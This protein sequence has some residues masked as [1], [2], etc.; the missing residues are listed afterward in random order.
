MVASALFQKNLGFEVLFDENP[1]N[2]L[3]EIHAL[4]PG[5]K[6]TEFIGWESKC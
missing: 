5:N 1:N 3:L 6:I 4:S 2:S